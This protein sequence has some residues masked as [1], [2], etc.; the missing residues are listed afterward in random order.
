MYRYLAKVR[1]KPDSEK[2]KIV[3]GS[4]LVIT[5]VI[6]GIWLITLPTQLENQV[7]T[8]SGDGAGNAPSPMQVFFNSVRNSANFAAGNNSQASIA[9]V[10]NNENP[11]DIEAS[12]LSDRPEFLPLNKL[13]F[14]P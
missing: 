7:A 10:L 8:S 13:E 9:E 14:L 3:L 5:A 6:A 1:Q 12:E 11:N 2:K 4:S